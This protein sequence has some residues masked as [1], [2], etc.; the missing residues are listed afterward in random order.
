MFVYFLSLGQEIGQT[1]KVKMFS[2]T[3]V[4]SRPLI[5]PPSLNLHKFEHVRCILI[6]SKHKF[7][8]QLARF[9]NEDLKNWQRELHDV[10]EALTNPPLLYADMKSHIGDCGVLRS[11]EGAYYRAKVCE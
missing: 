2:I 5:N 10:Y 6:L 7:F 9:S 3:A 8:G 4:V 11:S 1:L